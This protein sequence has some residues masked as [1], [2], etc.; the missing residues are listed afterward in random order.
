MPDK[1]YDELTQAQKF[2]AYKW[3]CAR[4]NPHDYWYQVDDTGK[5]VDVYKM[6]RDDKPRQPVTVNA[7]VQMTIFG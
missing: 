1:R 3:V 4:L 6:G 7:P 2:Q 5:V